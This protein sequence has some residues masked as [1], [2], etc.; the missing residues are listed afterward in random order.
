SN[1]NNTANWSNVTGGAGGFSV[2]GAGDNATF[3][4]NGLG[5]CTVDLA[6]SLATVTVNAAYTGTISQG[7]NPIAT[8][9]AA[10]FGGGTFLGGSANITFG[11]A[12]TLSGTAVFTATTAVLEFQGNS[13]FTAGTFNHNNGSVRYN[14]AAGTT[15]SGG[16][17]T[18]YNLEFVGNGFTVSITAG[19]L[20][21]TNTL[22]ISG[23]SSLTLNTGTINAN[24]DIMI[25]NSAK[26]GGGSALVNI[27]GTGV[28]TFTGGAAAGDG[29]LPQVTINKPSGTLNLLN[30]P[31][32]AN[33]FTYTAGTV[34][35]GTSTICF[36]R[37]TGNYTLT[38]SLTVN[39]LSFPAATNFAATIAVGTAITCTGDL[40]IAGSANMT[41]I[42]GTINVAGNL[43]LTNTGS[44][45]GGSTTINLDGAASQNIDG[46]AIAGNQD[47]L[48]SEE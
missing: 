4:G 11:G 16:A 34:N 17:E 2:P 27:V 42:T 14:R 37:S 8:T 6:L 26:G 31:S 28:E 7:A 33:A 21:V 12:F 38:G 10:V 30:F 43:I 29:A 46:T 19:A 44:S 13:A 15:I 40:T 24:G 35:A 25:T 48:R 39:N 18:F 9:G 5:N 23:S 20:T 3:D 1:W 32:I 47:L 22:M 41:L 45:G 36:S